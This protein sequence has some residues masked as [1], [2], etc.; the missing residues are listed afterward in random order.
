MKRILI[1]AFL[2]IAET[3]FAGDYPIYYE[4]FEPNVY[5]LI[6]LNDSENAIYLHRI[7]RKNGTIGFFYDTKATWGYY[8][9]IGGRLTRP[10]I[11]IKT[12]KFRFDYF[13]EK[14]NLI[15]IDKM[16]PQGKYVRVQNESK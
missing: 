13:E 4:R 10:S 16:G 15:E 8:P 12:G 7:T 14:S 5:S 6:I 2:L 1:I 11:W 3:V 9:K